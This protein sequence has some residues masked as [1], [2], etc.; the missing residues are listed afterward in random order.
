MIREAALIVVEIMTT[1]LSDEFESYN[2]DGDDSDDVIVAYVADRLG[3]DCDDPPEWISEVVRD[4]R[5]V[6]EEVLV[7]E[8]DRDSWIE[9]LCERLAEDAA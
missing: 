5:E 9:N 4:A 6:D 8:S 1:E 2:E 7:V 3:L